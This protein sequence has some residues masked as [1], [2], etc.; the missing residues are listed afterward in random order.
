M[1]RTRR[2]AGQP[3]SKDVD[4]IAFEVRGCR[5]VRVGVS[6]RLGVIAKGLALV[7]GAAPA[8]VF[9]LSLPAR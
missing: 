1:S 2:A 3:R 6:D 9:E 4:V 8:P 5:R 7:E